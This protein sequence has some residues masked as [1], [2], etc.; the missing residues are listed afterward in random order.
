MGGSSMRALTQRVSVLKHEGGGGGGSVRSRGP[1]K[2]PSSTA[3]SAPPPAKRR[4][5]SSDEKAKKG[6]AA[7]AP[8]AAAAPGGKKKQKRDAKKAKQAAAAAAA[9]AVSGEAPATATAPAGGAGAGSDG[10]DAEPAADTAVWLLHRVKTPAAA[11]AAVKDARVFL[12]EQLGEAAAAGAEV[13]PLTNSRGKFR[14]SVRVGLPKA[15]LAASAAGEGGVAEAFVARFDGKEYDGGKVKAKTVA[16]PVATTTAPA[17]AATD[18]KEEDAKEAAAPAAAQKCRQYFVGSLPRDMSKETGGPDR[19]E[20]ELRRAFAKYGLRFSSVK[21][22]VDEFHVLNGCAVVVFCKQKQEKAAQKVVDEGRVKVFGRAIRMEPKKTQDEMKE[23]SQRLV[24][25]KNV[26]FAGNIPLTGLGEAEV[27]KV[28]SR[29]GDVASVTMNCSEDGGFNGT[30]RITY[31]ETHSVA[32]AVHHSGTLLINRRPIRVD[33]DKRKAARSAQLDLTPAQQRSKTVLV[34]PSQP[35]ASLLP[36]SVKKLMS[37]I[38]RVRYTRRSTPTDDPENPPPPGSITVCFTISAC[39]ALAM[40]MIGREVDALPLV[41]D[42][43]EA[44]AKG[45]EAEGV[46]V[47]EK[48]DDGE[49][50]EEEGEEKEDEKKEKEK[51]KAKPT[52]LKPCSIMVRVLEGLD[53]DSGRSEEVAFTFNGARSWSN[54]EYAKNAR[55]EELQGWNAKGNNRW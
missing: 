22:L 48:E 45:E 1:T 6:E 42:G 8:A 24:G 11:A 54:K 36:S 17:A 47:E 26:V 52:G 35:N 53:R 29:F 55:I 44:A 37:T 51:E 43:A 33:F 27:T 3:A 4:N 30:A 23:S 19:L 31:R 5:T 46:D 13:R 28:F 18:E 12:A 25:D 2:R 14:G 21:V 9:A 40:Q 38:G 32:R 34:S 39:V 7:A 15:V 16:A 49:A 50:E 10:A 20:A 41:Q